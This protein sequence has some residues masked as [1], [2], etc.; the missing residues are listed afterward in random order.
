MG[1]KIW[2]YNDLTEKQ[3]DLNLKFKILITKSLNEESF[4]LL[5]CWIQT[6]TKW[7]KGLNKYKNK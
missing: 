3:K 7:A 5:F 6:N 2:K 4:D 1:K